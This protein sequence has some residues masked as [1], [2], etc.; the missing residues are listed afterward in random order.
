LLVTQQVW[1]ETSTFRETNG[2]LFACLLVPTSEYGKEIGGGE[3][4]G[5]WWRFCMF[6]IRKCA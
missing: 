6:Q 1:V 4:G 2:M 5:V 3:V